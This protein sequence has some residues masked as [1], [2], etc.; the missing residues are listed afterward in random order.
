MKNIKLINRISVTAA[1]CLP[2]FIMS[3]CQD[4]AALSQ[5]K[6]DEFYIRL[7]VQQACGHNRIHAQ[8]S[9]DLDPR[10]QLQQHNYPSRQNCAHPA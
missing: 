4:R 9:I 1:V 6:F 10:L 5:K 2:I 8:L 7:T 3:G